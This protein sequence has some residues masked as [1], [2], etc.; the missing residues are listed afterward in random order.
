MLVLPL[1][2]INAAN[3][4]CEQ[5]TNWLI[6]CI[7]YG[8]LGGTVAPECCQGLKELIAAKHTQD[9]RRRVSCHCIQEGAARI[10]GINYDRINDLPGLCST[11]C[12]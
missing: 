12:P 3:I 5:V 10:P 1:G 9:D 8:V 11:S 7:S 6:P 2:R 4:A